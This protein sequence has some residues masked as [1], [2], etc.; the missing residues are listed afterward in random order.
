MP[1]ISSSHPGTWFTASRP[2]TPAWNPRN[3]TA[4]SV[5][6][7]RAQPSDWPRWRVRAAG[8]IAT[9]ISGR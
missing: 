4:G 1:S 2:I 8:P 3:P 7:G 6:T 9:V 5:T